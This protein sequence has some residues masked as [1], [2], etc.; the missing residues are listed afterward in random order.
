[1][2]RSGYPPHKDKPARMIKTAIRQGLKYGMVHYREK[3]TMKTVTVDR[4]QIGKKAGLDVTVKSGS[5]IGK[6]FAPTWDMVMGYRN[7]PISSHQYTEQYNAILESVPIEVWRRL[8][9]HGK[10]SGGLTFLCYCKDGDFCHTN[11]LIQYLVD[12]PYDLF[13]GAFKRGG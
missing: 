5:G 8:Y 3:T 10:K 6:A 1:M 13:N 9:L 4:A 7:G 12:D 11:L 2:I